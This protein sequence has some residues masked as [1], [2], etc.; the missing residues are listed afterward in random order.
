LSADLKLPGRGWLEFEVLP[1]DGGRRSQIR[2]TATFDPRGLFGRAYWYGILPLHD[3]MFRGMLSS[4]AR[5][6]STPSAPASLTLGHFGHR[7][8]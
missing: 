3:L 6:A 1:L 7:H 4:I 8:H 5:R 2:Q